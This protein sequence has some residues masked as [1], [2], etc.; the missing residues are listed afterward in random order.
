[1]RSPCEHHSSIHYSKC[2]FTTSSKERLEWVNLPE[3]ANF[4]LHVRWMNQLCAKLVGVEHALAQ[5]CWHL[6]EPSTEYAVNVINTP[7]KH[8]LMVN[9]ISTIY[10]QLDLILLHVSIDPWFHWNSSFLRSRNYRLFKILDRSF[11][12]NW[13]N[14]AL[15]DPGM[16]EFAQLV[17]TEEVQRKLHVNMVCF[18][19]IK[20]SITICAVILLVL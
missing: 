20:R 3:W 9:L 2:H 8:H 15:W 17:L 16:T 11:S 6:K 12:I 13:L 1:M 14:M 7:R 18:F 10:Y 5:L 19:R 4:K